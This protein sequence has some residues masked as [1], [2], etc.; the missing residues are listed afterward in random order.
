VKLG[1]VILYVADVRATADFY[2]AAFGLKVRFV[3]ES[4]H[5]AEM[6]TGDTALGFANEKFTPTK[7][8]FIANRPD[9]QAAGTELALTTDDVERSFERAV[10]HGA[11]VVLVPVRKPW[12]QIV[13][14]VKD[15]NGFL[16]EICSV[17]KPTR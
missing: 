6:I 2:A 12:G 8:L 5:Y 10:K 13:S 7:G 11:T 3:H 4:G 1:Y 15:N 16:I 17:M 9:K 14:Y